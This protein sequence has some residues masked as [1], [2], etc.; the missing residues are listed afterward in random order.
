ML[1]DL[2][3]YNYKH[4]DAFQ[5]LV[6]TMVME[7]NKQSGNL[8]TRWQDYTSSIKRL[9]AKQHNHFTWKM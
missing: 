7:W 8:L 4:M 3:L 5:V 1:I 6:D 2:M 9:D